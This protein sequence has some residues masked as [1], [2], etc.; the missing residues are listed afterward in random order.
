[1]HTDMFLPSTTLQIDWEIKIL[2]PP[3]KCLKR[4][5]SSYTRVNMSQ[6]TPLNLWE[7]FILHGFCAF[8]L[9]ATRVKFQGSVDTC[10]HD[11]R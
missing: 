3:G 7:K 11:F 2:Q 10:D 5:T 9:Y 1:M 6:W 8:Y 4:R